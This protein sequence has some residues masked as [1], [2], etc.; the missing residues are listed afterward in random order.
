MSKEN[1]SLFSTN[2]AKRLIRQEQ[3]SLYHNNILIFDHITSNII[4][5][6]NADLNEMANFAVI[7]NAAESLFGSSPNV[8]KLNNGKKIIRIFDHQLVIMMVTES[9]TSES[10]ADFF[11]RFLLT[12]FICEYTEILKQ[13]DPF[14]D[15]APFQSFFPKIERFLKSIDAL[16]TFNIFSVF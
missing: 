13:E 2:L 14:A 5:F 15:I 11:L 12:I 9:T 3:G 7:T 10:E 8:I 16:K 6:N 4:V 1:L